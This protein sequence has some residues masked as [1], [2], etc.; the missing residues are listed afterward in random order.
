VA[1]PFA[2]APRWSLLWE[3]WDS[4]RILIG[5]FRVTCAS[6]RHPSVAGRREDGRVGRHDPCALR[7]D[8]P[9]DG[10]KENAVS[11]RSG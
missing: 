11:F 8:A 2:L 5:W 9:E 4:S 10:A 7:Q 6:L 1:V 3:G